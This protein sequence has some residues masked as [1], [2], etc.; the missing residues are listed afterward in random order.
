MLDATIGLPEAIASKSTMPRLSPPVAGE[1][2]M[3]ALAK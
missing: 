2:K 3:W 1:Q